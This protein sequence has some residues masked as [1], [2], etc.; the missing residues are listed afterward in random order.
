MT[1]DEINKRVAEIEGWV[2]SEDAKKWTHVA[3]EGPI[4]A[5]IDCPPPYATDWTWCGPL[6]PKYKITLAYIGEPDDPSGAFQWQAEWGHKLGSFR[7]AGT[8]QR[9]ICLAVM[10]AHEGK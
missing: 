9:A 8:P 3:S 5:W 1:D 7:Q 2:Y 4:G 10:A 6:V